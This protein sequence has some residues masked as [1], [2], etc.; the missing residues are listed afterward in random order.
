MNQVQLDSMDIELYRY[1][2]YLNEIVGSLSVFLTFKKNKRNLNLFSY[3]EQEKRKA[4]RR[5]VPSPAVL[6]GAGA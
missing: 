6:A 1:F 3:R 2:F 5:G 4:K